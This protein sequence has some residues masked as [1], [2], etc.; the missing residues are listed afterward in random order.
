MPM[1][2]PKKY[3]H[4]GVKQTLHPFH[5]STPPEVVIVTSYGKGT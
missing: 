2:P 5:F 3:T 4:T 1:Y